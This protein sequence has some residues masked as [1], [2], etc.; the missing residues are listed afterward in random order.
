ME[1][2]NKKIII[3]AGHGGID[4]GAIGNGLIEKELNLQA[5][6]YMYNRFKELGIPVKMTRK[7]DEYLPKT[8]RVN[9]VKELYNNDANVILISNHINAGGG[10]GAEVV[11][12]LKNEP[13]L[14][15]RVLD[16]IG[17]AGQIKRKIYQRRL[18]ENPNKD[19][20]YILRE[21]GNL[22]PILIEYGFIDNERDSEKLKNNLNDYAEAVVKAVAEYAGYRYKTPE[23]NKESEIYIVKK[24]DTLYSIANNYNITVAELKK[25]NN[26]ANNTIS[27]G[28][29]LYIKN[30]TNENITDTEDFYT[31]Q[32]GDT[33]YSISKKFNIS[34]EEIKKINNLKSNT[35]S[36]GQKLNLNGNLPDNETNEIE[37][38]NYTVQ[39][40][41]SLW[42]IAQKYNITVNELINLNELENTILQIGQNLKVPK[43][44]IVEPEYEI[45]IVKKGDTLWSISKENGLTVNEIKE[46]NNLTS[47]LLSVGQEIKIK[48]T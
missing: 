16:N 47:N 22:E 31:V 6:N 21:T 24:G 45:Y 1:E 14:A 17:A 34:V 26:L 11:Y 8:E 20:Y 10:E 9:R 13:T 2:L 15:Q 38:D 3:D 43:I 32:K 48:R 39:R 41:D 30:D 33:L 23:E 40:G 44:N 18:P 12:S 5:S 42:S 36:I 46:L 37:Y 4:G 35:L 25:I 7:D 29:K 19:Y 28:Q 27:I